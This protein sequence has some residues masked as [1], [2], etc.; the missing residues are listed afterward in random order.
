M[1]YYPI[2]DQEEQWFA[3]ELR[4]TSLIIREKQTLV[5]TPAGPGPGPGPRV[6]GSPAAGQGAGPRAH[7]HQ[8]SPGRTDQRPGVAAGQGPGLRVLLRAVAGLKRGS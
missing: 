4:N 1:K 5:P 8:Q 2:S 7:S 3:V 6:A